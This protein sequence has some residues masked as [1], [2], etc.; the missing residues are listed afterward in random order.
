[1]K[2]G[3]VPPQ[4]HQLTREEFLRYLRKAPKSNG[5]MHKFLLFSSIVSLV[6]LITVLKPHRLY[7]KLIA[8]LFGLS[9]TIGGSTF[10]LPHFLYIIAGFFGTIYM[11]TL[12]QNRQFIPNVMDDYHSKM[13]KLNS[14]WIN[15]SLSYL[16][17]LTMICV[18]AICR[19]SRLFNQ[20]VEYTQK[21]DQTVKE[22]EELKNGKKSS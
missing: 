8:F 17:F 7:K 6:F 20:E 16:S 3:A 14:K 15:E 2:V 19:N 4:Y 9:V 12:F 18:L 22:L 10:R 21:R 5:P 1:M 11:F 13:E